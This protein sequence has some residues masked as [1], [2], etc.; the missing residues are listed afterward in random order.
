MNDSKIH[1]QN[2]F[3]TPLMR[4]E[5]FLSKAELE[6]LRKRAT[7]SLNKQNSRSKKLTHS[8]A[9]R[10][11]EDK[12]FTHVSDKALQY[13]RDFGYLLFGENLNWTVKEMWLNVLEQGGHQTLHSHA[14][15]FISGI[16]YLSDSHTSAK[17][18]FHKSLG[19]QEFVFSN[20]H[21]NSNIT[22][23][24]AD[25]WAASDAKQGD[26]L[27]YPSSL[28]HAVPVN[29]GNQRITLAFNA[30]PDRLRSWDYEVTFNNR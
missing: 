9:I 26:L 22:P 2:L 18:M 7:Q 4:V 15:S 20:T 11:S 24:N 30:L 27:L 29:E 23:Y 13:L 28:L 19:G 21:A 1:L 16:L 3:P 17:T 10:A 25:R 5:S 14:N 12:E 6:P 8:Q